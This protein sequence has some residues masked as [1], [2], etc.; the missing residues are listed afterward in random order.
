MVLISYFLNQQRKGATKTSSKKKKKKTTKNKFLLTEKIQTSCIKNNSYRKKCKIPVLKRVISVRQSVSQEDKIHLSYIDHT[1][2]RFFHTGQ[3]SACRCPL[4]SSSSS[5]VRS[6]VRTSFTVP[7]CIVPYFKWS[8]Y[9]S[10][11][12]VD[13]TSPVKF[14]HSWNSTNMIQIDLND[15]IGFYHKSIQSFHD[16]SVV[17]FLTIRRFLIL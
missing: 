3:V 9:D 12:T 14:L 4:V 16:R 8:I 2:Q 13:R 5:S 17:T 7:E 10:G 15:L 1:G 6:I 11:M